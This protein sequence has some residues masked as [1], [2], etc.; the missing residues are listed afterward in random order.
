MARGGRRRRR[1][2]P[3][4]TSFHRGRTHACSLRLEAGLCL[5]G[6]DLNEKITPIE[7]SLAWLISARAGAAC[8]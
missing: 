3:P 5:Y 8:D 1:A 4:A 6:H 7:G 2:R